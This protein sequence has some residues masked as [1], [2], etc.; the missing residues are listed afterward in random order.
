VEAIT[1]LVIPAYLV[2]YTLVI[3]GY[4]ILIIRNQRTEF[5]FRKLESRKEYTV[6]VF[7]GLCPIVN[8]LFFLAMLE[9]LRNE[10]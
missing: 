4:I 7:V 2:T 10:T 3:I 9:E 5:A 8:I 6:A 1:N